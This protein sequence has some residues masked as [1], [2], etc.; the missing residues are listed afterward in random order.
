M[1]FG[2]V[3]WFSE[4]KGY[5]FIQPDDGSH[6]VFVHIT[7]VK[8]SNLEKLDEGQHLEFELHQR[9]DGRTFA[10]AMK[11]ISDEGGEEIEECLEE[12]E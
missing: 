1:A 9:G 5:G 3:K 10:Q 4:N 6:D 8:S 11:I 2:T 7:A 12:E